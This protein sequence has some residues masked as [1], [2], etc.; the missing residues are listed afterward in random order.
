MWSNPQF[1]GRKSHT[2]KEVTQSSHRESQTELAWECLPRT[3][4][5]PL[6]TAQS[7]VRPIPVPSD[8][9]QGTRQPARGRDFLSR[10]K[11]HTAQSTEQP[12][13]HQTVNKVVKTSKNYKVQRLCCRRETYLAGM[14]GK[15]GEC[16]SQSRRAQRNISEKSGSVKKRG[17]DKILFFD[18]NGRYTGAASN[19]H[20][21]IQTCLNTNFFKRQN[22]KR[23]E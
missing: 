1:I 13:C 21:L 3:H 2:C 17:S 5:F 22:K 6:L 15:Q 19:K 9:R 16:E 23:R 4:S 12:V 14:S 11:G 7:S 20:F 8:S 10:P 18:P